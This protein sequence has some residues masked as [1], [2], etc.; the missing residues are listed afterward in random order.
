MLV[1]GRGTGSS[2][3]QDAVRGST[4]CTRR[5]V[6]VPWVVSALLVYPSTGSG[7]KASR[8]KA[9]AI[10]FGNMQATTL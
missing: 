6:Q 10:S 5:S 2:R 7:H 3:G 8:M 9:L 1:A 4:V